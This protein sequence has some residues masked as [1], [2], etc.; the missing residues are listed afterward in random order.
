MKKLIIRNNQNVIIGEN[1]LND[2]DVQAFK[3]RLKISSPYGKPEHTKIITP[4]IHNED[5]TITPAVTEIV[6]SEYTIEE[7]DITAE[8]EAAQAKESTKKSDRISRVAQLKAVDFATITTVAQLKAIVKIL[9]KEA[10]KDD[11]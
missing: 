5:G 4:E 9:A 11:E 3:D 7:V 2:L 1:I 6:P 10:I 8:I